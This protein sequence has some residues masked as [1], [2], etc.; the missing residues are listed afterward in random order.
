[1]KLAKV[2]KDG[3]RSLYG[4]FLTMTLLPLLISG[5]GM[6]FACSYSLKMNI[7]KEADNNLT[8][9][10]S[11]VLAAYDVMYPGEFE[12]RLNSEG[13]AAV[14]YKGDQY[15]SDDYVFVDKIKQE[16][17]LEISIFIYDT[18]LITTLADKDGNRHV[19]SVASD[20]IMNE[21]YITGV[22]K[23]FNNVSIEGVNYYAYYEPIFDKDNGG[24]IGMIGIAKPA[25]MVQQSINKSIATNVVVMGIA[26][27]ITSV[28]IIMFANQIVLMIKYMIDFMKKLSD[29]KLDATINGRVTHR[30]DELGIMGRILVDLQ[31][32]LRRLIERDALTGLFNRRSAEKKIDKI[33]HDGIKY[34][35]SI[36]DIDHFKKFNDTFGHEC[37]DV[38]LKEVAAIL[39]SNMNGKGFVARWGGE[40]FL[41]VYENY[42]LESSYDA[43]MGIR[44]NLHE[45]DIMYGENVHKVTM[46]F[47]VAEKIE[48]IE[49]NE[50]IR[51][52][53]DK[54]YDGKQGGRDRVIR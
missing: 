38:V 12:A 43:L 51:M 14:L 53:D 17:N 3:S 30:S 37:G 2:A 11:A 29:N 18:R 47:G 54:L 46:T 40:E 42:D 15:I 19:G 39:N 35:V 32:S 41:L 52:A 31:I 4:Q 27:I 36:G 33:E 7:Q 24:V 28:F 25:E 23:F 9:M 20:T 10:A 21:V 13:T 48:G 22:P 50:L 5:I 6:I 8:N 44:E 16:R 45:K 26:I 49:I 34:C 1:M